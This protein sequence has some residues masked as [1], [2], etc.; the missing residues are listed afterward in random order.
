MADGWSDYLGMFGDIF[1]LDEEGE[2]LP[3]FATGLVGH[4]DDALV[5]GAKRYGS[6]SHPEAD[7]YRH[8]M[9]M[10]SAARDPDVG[11]AGAWFG[12]LGHELNNIRKAILGGDITQ[13]GSPSSR[14]G[15]MQI[16]ENSADDV[17]N[18]FWGILSSITHPE[19]LTDKE[20][21]EILDRSNIPPDLR[22]PDD[23]AVMIGDKEE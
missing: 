2:H 7:R 22:R 4:M 10:R 20:L 21:F 1:S 19:D 3:G 9:G 18:N 17:V 6:P 23:S 13:L 11:I 12:G 8:V 5:E 14:L 16:L 15:L